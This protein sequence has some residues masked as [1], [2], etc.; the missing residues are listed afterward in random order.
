MAGS[1]FS[2]GGLG[3]FHSA[4]KGL[5]RK[6]FQ[7][8]KGPVMVGGSINGQGNVPL[9][10]LPVDVAYTSIGKGEQ[11]V[12]GTAPIRVMGS[13]QPF[14][15]NPTL[16]SFAPAP[17]PS[18]PPQVQPEAPAAPHVS[19]G[20]NDEVHTLVAKLQGPSGR[21]YEAIY[22]VVVPE[23]GSQVLGVTERPSR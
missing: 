8:G 14:V 11:G 2:G 23:R 15:Q 17:Q 3:G 9:A 12:R 7:M 4:D 19:L 22:E 21:Q 1:Q 13:T 20:A 6:L 5:E 18:Y 16:G 10:A